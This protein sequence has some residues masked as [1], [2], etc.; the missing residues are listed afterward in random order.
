M[1]YYIETP[2]LILRDL[3]PADEEAM[4]R[5]NADPDVMRYVGKPL[6]HIDEARGAIAFIRSQ[7][8]KNGIGRWAVVEKESNEFIGWAGL[9]LMKEPVN[10]HVD[11]YDVG[12]R[13]MKQHWGKG[14]AT[15]ATCAALQYA[16]DVLK[17]ECVCAIAD[18]GN[19]ASIAVLKKVGFMPGNTFQFDGTEHIWFSLNRSEE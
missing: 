17:L 14:Y 1:R 6:V 19:G 11:Y 18:A 15:E 12:Y 8:E 3:L 2:R 7:Y 16:W 13:F 9:K 4:F 5:L 10:G